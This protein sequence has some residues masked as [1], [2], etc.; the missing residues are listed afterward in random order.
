MTNTIKKI[1]LN[2]QIAH[3]EGQLI[4]SNYLQLVSELE[5]ECTLRIGSTRLRIQDLS[6]L[7]TGQLLTL[8]QET[9]ESLE[10]L[11]NN[12]V[13]AKGELMSHED[14]FALRITE[15]NLSCVL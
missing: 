10:L 9:N 11:V 7:H 15:V 3:N 4:P 8:D 2:E 6:Q 5:L 13:I 14:K 1:T 12:Q